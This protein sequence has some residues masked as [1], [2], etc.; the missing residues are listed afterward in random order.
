[1]PLLR[2]PGYFD[3]VRVSG[4]DV[5]G[6]SGVKEYIEKGRAEALPKVEKRL[7]MLAD[8]CRHRR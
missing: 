3:I 5:Q 2:M 8:L 1:M 6:D 4:A 7:V